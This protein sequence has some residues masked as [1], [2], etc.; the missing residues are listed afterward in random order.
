M[1][2]LTVIIGAVLLLAACG[3]SHTSARPPASS[4]S[5]F[6]TTLVLSPQ[7]QQFVDAVR[8]TDGN[9]VLNKSDAEIIHYGTLVCNGIKG[10]GSVSQLMDVVRNLD[11]T[12][13]PVLQGASLN[14]IRTIVRPA[15]NI[16][17]PEYK[18]QLNQL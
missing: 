2:R 9:F 14:D 4:T 11:S 15:V 7:D 18:G 12:N 6:T 13:D 3:N 10:T 16:Y 17:C 1:K 5:Q 8:T